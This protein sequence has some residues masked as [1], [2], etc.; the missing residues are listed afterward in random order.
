MISSQT[1]SVLKIGS[2]LTFALVQD[3]KDESDVK[4]SLIKKPQLEIENHRF[5]MKI[6]IC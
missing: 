4:R 3:V 6:T 5:G 1:S 2:G